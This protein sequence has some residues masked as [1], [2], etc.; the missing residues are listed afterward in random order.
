MEV[1]KMDTPEKIESPPKELEG[2]RK[3]NKAEMVEYLSKEIETLSTNTVNARNRISFSLW[4]GP[5]L[6]LGSI[7]V[8]TQR[9]GFSP[10]MNSWKPWVAAALGSAC[11]CALGYIA[12]QIEAGAWEKCN[13]WRQCIIKLQ[14]EEEVLPQDLE[15]L[16]LYKPIAERV[17][18]VYTYVFLIILIIFIATAYLVVQPAQAGVARPAQDGVVQPAQGG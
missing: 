12:G 2:A 7:I 10:S 4:V 9:T 5:F 1:Q 18:R 13:E 6:V 17:S 8:A 14:L 16:I 15:K 11:F 3:I